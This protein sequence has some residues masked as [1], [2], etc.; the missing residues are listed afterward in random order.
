MSLFQYGKIQLSSGQE[1]N[2]KIECDYLQEQ[3]WHCLA[4]LAKERLPSFSSVE[5]VPSGGLKF[6]KYLEPF[7]TGK[8]VDPVLIVDD[9]LTTGRSMEKQRA[10]RKALGVVFI[11]RGMCPDWITPLYVQIDYCQLL[12]KEG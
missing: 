2:F 5:G 3:D 7:A 10:G 12:R 11:A 9:V 6:A 1:S 4:I 8:S